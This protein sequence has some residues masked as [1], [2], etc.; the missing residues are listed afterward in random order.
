MNGPT[1][2]SLDRRQVPLRLAAAVLVLLIVSA[3]PAF[4][5]ATVFIGSTAT[6]ANRSM[7]GLAFGA[8][9]LVFAFEF[10]FAQTGETLDEA[11]PSLGPEW[12][13]CCSKHQSRSRASSFT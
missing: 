2:L 10:E 5:D 6:P 3:A 13:M 1:R 7:K 9:L 11:A 4:A 8:G 12:A